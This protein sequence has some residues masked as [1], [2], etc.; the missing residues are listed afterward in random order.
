M[1]CRFDFRN[2]EKPVA[3]VDDGQVCP[4][5]DQASII[6]SHLRFSFAERI[7]YDAEQRAARNFL[8]GGFERP[9][10]PAGRCALPV[11]R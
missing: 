5:D 8:T 11:T 6:G 3:L 9:Q 2:M 1:A 10:Q 4:P 7:G